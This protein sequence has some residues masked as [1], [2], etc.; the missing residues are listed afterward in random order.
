MAKVQKSK[1]SS[2]FLE[3]ADRILGKGIVI[4]AWA[5]VSPVCIE[6]LPIEARVMSPSIETYLQYAEAIGLAGC[7]TASA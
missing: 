3:V 2:S 5:K 6:L 7:A 1:Y 4:D